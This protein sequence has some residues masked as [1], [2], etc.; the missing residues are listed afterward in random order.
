MALRDAALNS[1]NSPQ[2]ARPP[3]V[4]RS[5]NA[6]SQWL[7]QEFVVTACWMPSAD[8]AVSLDDEPPCEVESRSGCR[9]RHSRQLPPHGG[10]AEVDAPAEPDSESISIH[11][12]EDVS[13][14]AL[15]AAKRA[16]SDMMTSTDQPAPHMRSVD[17]VTPHNECDPECGPSLAKRAAACKKLAALPAGLDI[18]Q[19][20]EKLLK[21]SEAGVSKFSASCTVEPWLSK[22]C[23]LFG[24]EFV[25]RAVRERI[26]S[27]RQQPA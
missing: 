4:F 11:G 24:I 22:H 3:C 20:D 15:R 9:V 14:S 19:D 5:L 10:H 16:A 12:H 8:D 25:R 26:E 23:K 27:L 7:P 2:E 6:L 17:S 13:R 1:D 18:S 21:L